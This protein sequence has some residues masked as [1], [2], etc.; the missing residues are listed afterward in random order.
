[1]LFPL[2]TYPCCL[3]ERC[4]AA[5]VGAGSIIAQLA[6]V[7]IDAHIIVGVLLSGSSRL[8]R[9]QRAV[10]PSSRSRCL[11]IRRGSWTRGWE[12]RHGAFVSPKA[13]C[14]QP[15]RRQ[16][17]NEVEP[18]AYQRLNS[19]PDPC[20]LRL[21]VAR[22]SG[23]DRGPRSRTPPYCRLSPHRPP[24]RSEALPAHRSGRHRRDRDCR[25]ESDPQN[26]RHAR[27]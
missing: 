5:M 8:I 9:A 24:R 4:F 10:R 1:M 25:G 22:P 21:F 7:S 26:H 11:T 16:S 17:Q 12:H 6:M 27:R 23:A 2:P 3:I 18:L 20:L 15:Q 13:Q 19:L 14:N